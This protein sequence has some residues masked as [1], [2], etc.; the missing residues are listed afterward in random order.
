M[1]QQFNE[2]LFDLP[3]R[4]C[5]C[6]WWLQT[7]GPVFDPSSYRCNHLTL[8]LFYMYLEFVWKIIRIAQSSPLVRCWLLG[9]LKNKAHDS[10][11]QGHMFSNL[12]FCPRCFPVCS[13]VKDQRETLDL[14]PKKWRFQ[15]LVSHLF[16]RKPT[17]VY[18]FPLDFSFL[19][20][21]LEIII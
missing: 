6:V 9:H 11:Q 2:F 20:Y 15:F 5:N 16:S 13:F 4:C 18:H 17:Q 3:K 10:G 8:Y 19:F 12:D 1:K 14:K 21:K 7:T